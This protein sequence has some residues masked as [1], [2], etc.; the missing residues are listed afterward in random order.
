MHL[1]LTCAR[2]KMGMNLEICS[3]ARESAVALGHMACPFPQLIV[4][5]QT[6]AFSGTVLPFLFAYSRSVFQLAMQPVL[7]PRLK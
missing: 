6:T 2:T 1:C 7:L 4:L 3:S 5:T